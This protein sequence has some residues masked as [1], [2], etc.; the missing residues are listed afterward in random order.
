MKSKE[1]DSLSEISYRLGIEKKYIQ[2][3]GGNSSV[4]VNNK[5]WVKA[6]G[7]ELCNAIKQNIFVCLD[8]DQCK[9]KIDEN[10]S[11][12]LSFEPIEEGNNKP[13]IETAFHILMP[14]KFVIHTHSLDI[15]ANTITD[16]GICNIKKALDGMNWDIIPYYRPG[17]PLAKAIAGILNKKNVDILL[18]KNH[19]VIV[20]GKNAKEAFEIHEQVNKRLKII[21]RIPNCINEEKIN[22]IYKKLISYGLNLSLPK[23][24]IV[25]SLATDK[26]SA[27]LTRK[28]P[29]YPD[30]V[31]FCGRK[32]TILLEEDI[33][34]LK[35]ISYLKVPYMIIESIG[36]FLCD[37]YNKATEDMLEAQAM[38]NLRIKQ[39]SN[40]STLSNQECEELINWDEEK[41]RISLMRNITKRS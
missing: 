34:K 12:E 27:E 31:V 21:E 38:I 28:N 37:G 17:L 15:I 35:S 18:L 39:S 30:H 36:V 7:L 32:P 3:A 20:G 5:I 1:L 24:N 8:L 11:N 23:A 41:Y 29:L 19:G 25:H 14:H 22:F 16:T 6:S 9:H 33:M 4:K 26:L 10:V 2:G 13:S 40:V